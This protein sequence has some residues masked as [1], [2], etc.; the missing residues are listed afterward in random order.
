MSQHAIAD[1][2]TLLEG[3]TQ[4]LRDYL[5]AR[6]IEEPV[7]IGIHTGGVWVAQEL[8]RRLGLQHPLG[9]LD[10]SFYRDDFSRIG[11]H[12][13][14]KPSNLPFEV[15]ERAIILV[16]DVL[17]S[18]RTIRAALNEIFD[19]GRPARVILAVLIERSGHELPIRADIKG[20]SMALHADEQV[21]LT[22]PDPMRLSIQSSHE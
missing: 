21:K 7:M 6:Q 8:H 15:E 22:G 11:M 9:T 1:V 16:D 19:Y 12:P 4:Q 13:E 5:A 2:D 14:V 17:Q 18:G 3:M 10:I 20:A